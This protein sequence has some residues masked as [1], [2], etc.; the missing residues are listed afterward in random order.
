MVL[1][2]VVPV[3]S[4]IAAMPIASDKTRR[5]DL[6]VGIPGACPATIRPNAVPALKALIRT[7]LA[8]GYARSWRGR[9]IRLAREAGGRRTGA[10]GP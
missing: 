2:R 7:K 4:K 6:F 1:Y 10:P 3:R 9:E 8:L 5:A